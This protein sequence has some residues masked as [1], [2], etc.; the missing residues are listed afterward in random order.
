MWIVV[1]LAG[2][3]CNQL[4]GID[5]LTRIDASGN[6]IDAPLFDAAPID[7][8]DSPPSMTCAMLVSPAKCF[9]NPT[10]AIT[11]ENVINTDPSGDAR[12]MSVAQSTGPELCAIIGDTITVP[13][14]GATIT[15]SRP[16]LL[17]ATT[18]I[19]VIGVLD[20]SSTIETTARTGPG[21]STPP[22]GCTLPTQGGGNDAH[23]GGAGGSFIT[24][25][26]DGGDGAGQQGH[27]GANG[28]NAL[29]TTVLRAGCRGS[30]GG[31]G[32]G[33]TGGHGGGAIYLVAGTEIV[34]SNR[35]I[36]NGAGGTGATLNEGGGGGGG[37]GGMIV[38]DASTITM[39]GA[40]AQVSANGGGGG[41]G[42]RDTNAREGTES[43]AWNLAALGGS[44][45]SLEGGAGGIGAVLALTGL[46]ALNGTM[47]NG[48]DGGGGGGGGGGGL[49]WVK[50]TLAGA[51]SAQISPPAV[52]K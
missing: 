23:G 50:G 36:A 43:T 7:S 15:G 48:N 33:G 13:A 38:L 6:P 20:A 40:I 1:A 10:G 47:I 46:D 12:C 24:K 52:P 42:T 2:T 29:T 19:T 9:S 17:L 32:D 37:S 16:L 35:V 3:G 31:G 22:P 45:G 25:G 30:P 49:V 34:I 51:Q 44:G 26:G 21:T 28:A 8:H 18:R 14:A 11:I 39:N 41:E 4:L 5:E 27:S